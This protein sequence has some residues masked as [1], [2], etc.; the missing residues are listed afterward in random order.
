LPQTKL[1]VS[2]DKIKTFYLPILNVSH[3]NTPASS[4]IDEKSQNMLRDQDFIFYPTQPRA[5][6]NLSLLL[7]V[8]NNLLKTRSDLKLVLTSF[9]H[10][11]SASIALYHHLKLKNK[12]IFLPKI[13]DAT[14][15]WLYQQAACLCLTSLM[16]GNFPPQIFEA[17]E[18]G[19]PIV[20]TR[21]PLI[22]E[23]LETHSDHLLLCEPNNIEEF[24]AKTLYALEHRAEILAKQ[25]VALEIVR[26]HGS[27]SSFASAIATHLKCVNCL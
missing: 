25:H 9:L 11:D 5:N 16:E 19:T 2:L 7:N 18:Y 17:L 8:F 21:L 12:V 13:S 27:W 20:A 3:K 23:L 15:A 1:K 22:T 10:A 14:L 26:S 24:T 6:K 4:K